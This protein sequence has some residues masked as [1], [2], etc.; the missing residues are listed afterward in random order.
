MVSI[1]RGSDNFDSSI[2]EE[3]TKA[4]VN[5]NGQGTVAIR[6]DENVSSISDIGTGNTMVSFSSNM[7]SSNY[8]WNGNSS[9]TSANTP[10]MLCSVG[11][12]YTLSTSQFQ[13]NTVNSTVVQALDSP[14]VMTHVTNS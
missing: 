13:I 7:S 14:L 2:S 1:I 4:W 3:S 5:F 12:N 6:D 10:Y 8:I 9:F 11:S